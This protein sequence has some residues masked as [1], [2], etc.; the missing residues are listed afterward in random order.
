MGEKILWVYNIAYT[1]LYSH[2]RKSKKVRASEIK[3]A[4]PRRY[5]VLYLPLWP[6][7]IRVSYRAECVSSGCAWAVAC[8]GGGHRGGTT[9]QT[10]QGAPQAGTWGVDF[11]SVVAPHTGG[12]LVEG[13]THIAR[14]I[15]I[16]RGGTLPEAHEASPPTVA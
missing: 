2:R 16:E 14:G 4:T 10:T 7:F 1:I 13:G 15:I 12:L 8:R 9:G 3:R 11:S 5:V 6:V